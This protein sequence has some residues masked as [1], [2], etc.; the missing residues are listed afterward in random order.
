M[1]AGFAQ[2]LA[3]YTLVLPALLLTQHLTPPAIRAFVDKG[4]SPA[5]PKGPAQRYTLRRMLLHVLETTVLKDGLP[6]RLINGDVQEGCQ[7]PNLPGHICLQLREM[8]QA[9]I[10]QVP[11]GPP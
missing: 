5:I 9:D 1:R 11:D 7:T 2:L 3:G 4:L 10:W 8:D 6:F